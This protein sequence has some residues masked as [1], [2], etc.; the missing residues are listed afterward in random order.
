MECNII[1]KTW[2]GRKQTEMEEGQSGT[3]VRQ[4]R[5]LSSPR[6][7]IAK[8]YRDETKMN[9]SARSKW[10]SSEVEYRKQNQNF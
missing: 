1:R 8:T 2:K 7:S 3:Y 6:V 9:I 5:A 10:P 4:V